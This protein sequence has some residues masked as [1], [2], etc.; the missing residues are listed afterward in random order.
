MK[1]QHVD[2][3]EAVQIH[4]D[5]QAKTSLAVHWGTFALAYEV[6]ACLS[7]AHVH[8]LSVNASTEL[9]GRLSLIWLGVIVVQLWLGSPVFVVV[10]CVSLASLLRRAGR[11]IEFV[12]YSDT[13]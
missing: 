3:E 12:Q 13:I 9:A 5:I 1:S 7:L 6:W 4:M 11:Y 10:L 2:P 8:S